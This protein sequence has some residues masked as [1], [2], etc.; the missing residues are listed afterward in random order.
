MMPHYIS[1]IYWKRHAKIKTFNFYLISAFLTVLII[2]KKNFLLESLYRNKERSKK[3][4]IF[5]IQK[6]WPDSY[7]STLLTIRLGHLSLRSF[8][9]HSAYASNLAAYSHGYLPV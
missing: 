5:K 6:I 1:V 9:L 3:L 2:S 4:N 7:I 8:F